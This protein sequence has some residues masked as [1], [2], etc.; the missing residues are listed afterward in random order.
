MVSPTPTPL[1]RSESVSRALVVVAKRP[2][3]GKTKT[4]LSPPLSGSEAAALYRCLLLDTLDLMSQVPGVQPIIAYLPQDAGAFFRDIAPPGFDLLPQRGDDLGQRL[5]N[6]LRRCLEL[7][8]SQAVVMNSDGP[9]LPAAYLQKAFVQLDDSAVDVVLGP[10]EDGG[11]YLIGLKSPCSA[12]F[13]GIVMS[14]STVAQET[15]HRAGQISLKVSCLPRWHDV[16]TLTD[17]D[18]LVAELRSLPDRIA[19]HTREFLGSGLTEV[20][21]IIDDDEPAL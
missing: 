10:S 5:D 11:Y 3:V 2:S 18:R 13:E 1:T 6:V 8:Y 21:G 16:D 15:L 4:R 9:T 12:L 17:L 14:T 19:Q 7:G 20:A